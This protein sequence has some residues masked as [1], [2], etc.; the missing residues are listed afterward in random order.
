MDMKA[1]S[2]KFRTERQVRAVIGLRTEQFFIILPVFEKYL[3]A[4]KE[5]D[6]EDKIKPENGQEGLLGSAS[7]KLF[8][9]LCYLKCYSSF[10]KLGFD[11]NMSGS[12]AHTWLFKLLPIFT[13]TLASFEVLPKMNFE[14]P[15]Q[16]REAFKGFETLIIDATERVIQRPQDDRAQKEHFSGKSR[17]HTI[18]NTIVATLD[19]VVLYV[20]CTFSGKNHDYGMFKKEFTSSLSWFANFNIVVDLGYEGFNKDYQTKSILIPHKKPQQSKNNPHP[21]LTKKQK[22]ENR[23]ISKK[24]VVVENVIAGI[25]RLKCVSDRY[26]NHRTELKDLFILLAAGIWNFNIAHRN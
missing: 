25:K 14:T 18:K 12:S 23:K 17:Q 13:Q 20:G 1:I 5:A 24:R 6:K 4:K 9:I 7:D 2:E 16:M 26:R 15:E 19:F 3:E 21:Q 11:F 8:F 22:D 10:D